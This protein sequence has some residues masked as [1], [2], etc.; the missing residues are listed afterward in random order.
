MA[1]IKCPGCGNNVS[2]KAVQCPKCGYNVANGLQNFQQQPNNEI[3]EVAKKFNWG[4]FTLL[5][6]W[7]FANGMWWWILITIAIALIPFGGVI[8]FAIAIY[9]G[10]KGGE[11]AWNKK[12]WRDINHFTKVYEQWKI[13]A[14]VVWVLTLLFL[15]ISIF[16]AGALFSS[17]D[18]YYYY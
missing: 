11:M 10:I 5:P 13:A 1:I 7:G 2:D 17:Y 14:I 6:L 16:A 18:D 8:N 4:A 15:I 12:S 9:M 3:P